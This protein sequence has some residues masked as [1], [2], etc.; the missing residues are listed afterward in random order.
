MPCVIIFVFVFICLFSEA[1]PLDEMKE[2]MR[3]LV[4][5]VQVHALGEVAVCC[6]VPRLCDLYQPGGVWSREHVIHFNRFLRD[7]IA[8]IDGVHIIRC[9]EDFIYRRNVVDDLYTE[10]GL[11]LSEGGRDVLAHKICSFV[12]R[13]SL[14]M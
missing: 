6:L 10:D 9:N 2:K 11:H 1:L 5:R 13:F 3:A 4:E 7:E 8:L 12:D 14:D